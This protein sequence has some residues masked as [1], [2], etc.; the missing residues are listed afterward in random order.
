VGINLNGGFVVSHLDRQTVVDVDSLFLL[1]KA[2]PYLATYNETSSRLLASI[3]RR[4][5]ESRQPAH[6]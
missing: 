1:G 6:R 5:L 2:V 3:P 4:L